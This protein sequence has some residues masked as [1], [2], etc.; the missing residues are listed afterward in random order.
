MF[1]HFEVYDRPFSYQSYVLKFTTDILIMEV[2]LSQG[3]NKRK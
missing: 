3:K 1:W 2:N